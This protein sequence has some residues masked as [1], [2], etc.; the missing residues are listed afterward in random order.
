MFL[1]KQ[2]QIALASM[3]VY[4]TINPNVFD[5]KSLLPLSQQK[6]G[7]CLKSRHFWILYEISPYNILSHQS[8]LVARLTPNNRDRAK[9]SL[10]S[11]SLSLSLFI[12]SLEL[13]SLFPTINVRFY[14]YNIHTPRKYC[15]MV[16]YLYTDSFLDLLFRLETHIYSAAKLGLLYYYTYIYNLQKAKICNESIFVN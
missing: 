11:N 3:S 8:S 10:F 12:F 13:F 7:F 6:K 4:Y 1:N 16:I 9:S 2:L 5:I 15:C 14:I